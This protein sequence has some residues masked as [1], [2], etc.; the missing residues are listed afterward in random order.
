MPQQSSLSC[1]S[2]G[3]SSGRDRVFLLGSRR[4]SELGERRATPRDDT[5]E[6]LT[7]SLSGKA[8]IDDQESEG[9]QDSAD[10]DS[11]GYDEVDPPDNSP[12]V[13]LSS[14]FLLFCVYHGFL[15]GLL[16]SSILGTDAPACRTAMLHHTLHTDKRKYSHKGDVA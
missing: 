9:T 1:V 15:L 6:G 2:A 10:T 3:S 8:S 14:N 12:L 16:L 11:E 7:L 5:S 13:F 4:Q